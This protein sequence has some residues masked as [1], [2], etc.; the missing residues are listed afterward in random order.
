MMFQKLYKHLIIM[1]LRGVILVSVFALLLGCGVGNNK[2][3]PLDS[4]QADRN[5]SLAS[6]SE[7][8][9]LQGSEK[10]AISLG[11]IQE[12]LLPINLLSYQPGPER[13]IPLMP[14][15]R[16]EMILQVYSI[17]KDYQDILLQFCLQTPDTGECH[18]LEV[19][20]S[21]LNNYRDRLPVLKIPAEIVTSI[22]VSLHIPG[23]L[24]G[25]LIRD[26]EETKTYPLKVWQT[27][28]PGDKILLK[29]IKIKLPSP[30]RTP[31]ESGSDDEKPLEFSKAYDKD[32]ANQ[33]FG[34]FF[35][36]DGLARFHKE[37][38]DLK[39]NVG[40]NVTLFEREFDFYRASADI[41]TLYFRS[42]NSHYK[43]MTYFLGALLWS[44]KRFGFG[45]TWSDKVKWLKEKKITKTIFMGPIPVE[46][47]AGASGEIG[48][49]WKI[50]AG[51][52]LDAK[53]WP[54]FKI[55]TF[56][57]AGVTIKAAS[58]GVKGTLD[59]IGDRL[60]FEGMCYMKPTADNKEIS[61]NLQFTITNDLIGP[62]G[63]LGPFIKWYTP[64]IC[65][66]RKCFFRMCREVPIPCFKI[67]QLTWWWVNW[68]AFKQ[69]MVLFD[70]T[71]SKTFLLP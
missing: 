57:S 11:S 7:T 4:E 16:L 70:K 58:S 17:S 60:F 63:R 27:Q 26:V 3:G 53:V 1:K 47:T 44:K 35:S 68:T 6:D 69:K 40:V 64:G 43:Y 19:W 62:K 8:P 59:L 20:D 67:N 50:I 65:W 5:K 49:E 15:S 42:A 55:G 12:N 36:M 33:Y 46:V 39:G 32:F 24:A 30:R 37:G 45:Y 25:E 28:F 29:E 18:P 14:D 61:G 2:S 51:T 71:A 23:K 52:D 56:A 21:S 54:Y 41:K 10:L 9:G 13:I 22:P 48:I 66:K 31:L 38:A 34:A